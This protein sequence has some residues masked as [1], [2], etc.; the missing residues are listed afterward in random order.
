MQ[1]YFVYN[2]ICHHLLTLLPELY[3]VLFLQRFPPRVEASFVPVKTLYFYKDFFP[4]KQIIYF[5]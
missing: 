4:L 3:V 5:F 2:S 1:L